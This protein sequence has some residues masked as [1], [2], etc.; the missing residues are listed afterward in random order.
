MQ[1]L[2][3]TKGKSWTISA[4]FI[5]AL[6]VLMSGCTQENST[7]VAVKQFIQQQK[8]D[9]SAA[10][11]RTKLPKPPQFKFEQGQTFYWDLQTNKGLLSIKLMPSIAPMHVSSTMYLT[12]LGYYDGLVFHRV[13]NGFMAQGGDPLGNGTGGPGYQYGGEFSPEAKHNKAGMLSMANRGPNTDGSQFFI[14]FKATPYLDGR[15]TI[16]GELVNGMDTLKVIEGLGSY[17]GQTKEEVKIVTAKIRIVE[18]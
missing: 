1:R 10:D 6:I 18:S 11:W 9:Q 3:L 12:Q 16:F 14:T 4:L 7:L 13:I 15:H 5:S 17:S 2:Q 8:I